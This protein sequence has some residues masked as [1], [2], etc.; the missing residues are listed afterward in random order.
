M[1]TALV[2]PPF[3]NDV[4]L[5]GYVGKLTRRGEVTRSPGVG[6]ATY[7]QQGPAPKRPTR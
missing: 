2:L 1:H 3:R 4:E 7:H 6:R 5:A